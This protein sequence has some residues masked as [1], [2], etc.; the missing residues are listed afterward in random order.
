M[1]SGWKRAVIENMVAA[2]DK[3]AGLTAQV[4]EAEIDKLYSKIGQ[5]V[6]ERDFLKRA[7]GR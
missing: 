1:I 6:V 3:N 4:S 5:L 7:F 2:F